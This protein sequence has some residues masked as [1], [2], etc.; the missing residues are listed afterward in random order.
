MKH[1]LFIIGAVILVAVMGFGIYSFAAADS[2]TQ[3]P[4]MAQ[5]F[6]YVTSE[7]IL[8]GSDCPVFTV[9]SVGNGTGTHLGNFTLVRQHCFTPPGHP[10]FTG[11]VIHDGSYEITSANGD[12]I[13]GSY[14]GELQPSEYGDYGPIRGV[15]ISPS[16]IDGGTGSFANAQG[17]F[18]ALG[19]YDLV[20]D[21]GEFEFSGW[22]S[23]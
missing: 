17:D 6:E 15:I 10:A 3:L 5:S 2:D 9:I 18:M 12:K 14:S 1:S 22:I 8:E 23:Y 4:F 16:T 7:G 11:K 21:E 13:W 19:D 20:A